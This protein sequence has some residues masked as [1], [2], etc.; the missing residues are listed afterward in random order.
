MEKKEEQSSILNKSLK[1][2]AITGGVVSGIAFI[3]ILLG[4]GT[5]GI[6]AG[7]LAAGVQSGIGSVAAGSTFAFFQSLGMTSVFATTAAIGG[8]T[9]AVAAGGLLIENNLSSK[10]KQEEKYDINNKKN[11]QF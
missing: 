1:A 2:V 7:T 9:S 11:I 6:G 4:F 10:E 8:S 3:P 5:A